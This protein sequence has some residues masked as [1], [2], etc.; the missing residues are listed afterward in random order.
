MVI[1]DLLLLSLGVWLADDSA[2]IVHTR[3]EILAADAETGRSQGE[4]VRVQ[5]TWYTEAGSRL[6]TET[7]SAAGR[8]LLR[9]YFVLDP[10]GEESGAVY[11][12]EEETLPSRE[13]FELSPDGRTRKVCYFSAK[14]EAQGCVRE[15]LDQRKLV[16][17][18]RYLRRDGSYWAEEEVRHSPA[19]DLLGWT[20]RRADGG[21]TAR[22]DYHYTSFDPRGNWL[23]RL[24]VRDGFP[25]EFE[26]RTIR[27]AARENAAGGTPA[28][29]VLGWGSVSRWNSFEYSP[30]IA[31]GGQ[32]LTFLRA[33]SD[34]WPDSAARRPM[35]ARRVEGRW[36]VGNLDLEHQPYTM[37]L[38]HDGEGVFYSVRDPGAQPEV[39]VF[40][41]GLA[42]PRAVRDL[43]AEA[44]IRGSYFSQASS[45]AL[46]FSA[47][48]GAEGGGVYLS[49]QR[50]G[51]LLAPERLGSEVN[52]RGAVTFGPLVNAAETVLLFTRY[53]EEDGEDPRGR[54]GLYRS[55]RTAGGWSKAE[56]L[57]GLPYG[58]KP[59]IDPEAGTL[60][61][62][63]GRD[64]LSIPLAAAGL[65]ADRWVPGNSRPEN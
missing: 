49:Q 35:V 56:K 33:E 43:T 14:G 18:K 8:P 23:E 5:R 20:F 21:E 41:A 58:W 30:S 53:Y 34:D 61:F 54:S 52:A 48:E 32:R 15:E 64:L 27:Y 26:R 51:R 59:A 17:T 40:H 1:L 25:I 46:Y 44:G 36:E 42:S 9:M 7:V 62:T 22:F 63:D 39:R 12:E 4:P 29:E 55:R 3:T 16:R 24:K 45:G 19:G 47:A 37:S 65:S 28:L 60:V 13:D 10:A 50:E 6:R 2:W 38:S 31:F 11:F 57:E